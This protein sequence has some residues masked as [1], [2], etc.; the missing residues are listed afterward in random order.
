M[1]RF[2]TNDQKD[3]IRIEYDLPIL[4]H[5]AKRFGKKLNYIGMPGEEILDLRA[6]D[7]VLSE[8]VTALEWSGRNAKERLITDRIKSKIV[9]LSQRRFPGIQ[10]ITESVEVVIESGGSAAGIPI[11]SH[12]DAKGYRRFTYD[13]VNLDYCGGNTGD[14]RE[15]FKTLLRRQ[16]GTAF[17]LLLSF[18]VRSPIVAQHRNTLRALCDGVRDRNAKRIVSS[19]LDGGRGYEAPRLSLMIPHAISAFAIA[20]KFECTTYPPVWY[21]GTGSINMAHFGFRLIPQPD[22]YIGSSKQDAVDRINLPLLTV[23]EKALAYDLRHPVGAE[24]ER[25][26]IGPGKFLRDLITSV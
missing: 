11:K 6:W 20:E 8:D 7:S 2:T 14:R 18:S 25:R 26:G 9:R 16:S 4:H 5:F 17:V 1:D 15:T 22:S 19:F 21:E 12:V 3:C 23:Q 24:L 10:V 13:L